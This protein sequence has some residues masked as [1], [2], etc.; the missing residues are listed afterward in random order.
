MLGRKLQ[1]KIVTKL[2][3]TL[4]DRLKENYFSF[5]FSEKLKKWIL[6]SSFSYEFGARPIK[7]FI[8]NEVETVIATNIIE[9]KVD[10]K[11]KYLV[12]YENNQVTIK[13][14]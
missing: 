10:T 13:A 9:G 11:H 5:E 4:N 14:I 6:D 8:S 1:F 2:L 7:R 3:N 12:D